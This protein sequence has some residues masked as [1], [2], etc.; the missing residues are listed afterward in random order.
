[1]SREIAAAIAEFSKDMAS[2]EKQ[3]LDKDISKEDADRRRKEL[4]KRLEDR[5]E[6]IGD[7]AEAWSENLGQTIKN[8][9][10]NLSDNLKLNIEPR[11]RIKKKRYKKKIDGLVMLVGTNSLLNSPVASATSPDLYAGPWSPQGARSS[12]FGL[13][14]TDQRRV[15]RSPLWFRSGWG[16]TNY[17]YDFGQSVL[18]F[19]LPTGASYDLV[20]SNVEL[21]RSHLTMSYFE[22]PLAVVI[23]PS[24]RGKGLNISAGGFAGIRLGG[25][26][27]VV[28]RSEGMGRVVE[29]TS[30]NFY[31][32]LFSYGLQAELGYRRYTVGLR[33]NLNRPFNEALLPSNMTSA[34]VP[35][36]YNAS[37]FATV[38]FF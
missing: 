31:G 38:R 9:E 3:I 1:M 6:A 35:N 4:A 32:G 18:Q 20:A 5:L 13:Y 11:D 34:T 7:M 30:G 25:T 2:L 22:V 28:Y 27:Q 33:Q 16:I 10:L 17:Q 12:T 37:V 29:N 19:N 21:R 14:F 24:R 8:L 23:N 26:R 36:F 15:G